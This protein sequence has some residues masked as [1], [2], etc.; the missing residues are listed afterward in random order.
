MGP[1]LSEMQ[2]ARLDDAA[3]ERL[4]RLHSAI[5][6]GP[7]GELVS[8]VAE[9]VA[10]QG[11]LTEELKRQEYFFGTLFE[12]AGQVNTHSFNIE[13]MQAYLSNTL[14]GQFA[15]SKV[16]IFRADDD[17]PQVLKLLRKKSPERPNELTEIDLNVGDLPADDLLDFEG[18]I[19]LG[20]EGDEKWQRFDAIRALRQNGFAVVFPL[21]YSQEHGDKV[22]QG[23][24]CLGDRLGGQLFSDGDLK[25]L[26]MLG[27]M[28][29][30]C[31]YNEQ[32][33]RRSVVDDLTKVSSR[34][35]FDA[36]LIREVQR[37]DRY[38]RGTLGLIMLD[39]DHFKRVN[40]KHG[41]P[42]G[43][44]VL[45]QMAEIIRRSIRTTDDV[46]RYGGEEFAITV[47]EVPKLRALEVTE[48]IRAAIEAHEMQVRDDVTVRITASLGIATY[49][50]DAKSWSELLNRA[51]QALY[52]SKEN[53]RNMVTSYK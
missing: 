26:A 3:R 46:A 24:L 40:D 10:Q 50:H 21:V 7:D 45:K 29:A 48:R 31:F 15:V 12:M 53:G 42:V 1:E 20:A 23:I 36:Q 30:V 11:R 13:R 51:D 39:L 35:Y 17:N 6:D 41:H 49:P 44:Q 16:A 28:I 38:G 8:W 47:I 32:L 33:Y 2:N 18:S 5:G 34:G 52:R 4:D 19:R 22:L 9:A 43:D 37:I 25:M 27:N 14:R